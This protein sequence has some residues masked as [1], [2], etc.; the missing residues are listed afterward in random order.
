M[1]VTAS[2]FYNN[3]QESFYIVVEHDQKPTIVAVKR[4]DGNAPRRERDAIVDRLTEEVLFAAEGPTCTCSGRDRECPCGNRLGPD[5]VG[6]SCANG[7]SNNLCVRCCK[8]GYCCPC[9]LE[10]RN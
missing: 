6:V 4:I 7:D 8:D 3:N 1:T 5:H 10:R 9:N 2:V